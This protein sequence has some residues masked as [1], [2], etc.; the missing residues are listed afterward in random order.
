MT[1]RGLFRTMYVEHYLPYYERNPVGDMLTFHQF[2]I[3]LR[4]Q[5]VDLE[6]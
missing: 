2:L 6:V 5:V 1:D 3:M 4:Q